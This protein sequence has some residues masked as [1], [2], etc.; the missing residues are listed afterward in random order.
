[1]TASIATVTP[2]PVLTILVP[3]VAALAAV[4]L[5]RRGTVVDFVAIPAGLV[6][7]LLTAIQARG[8]GPSFYRL[9][10]WEAP[11]GVQLRVDGLAAAFL[12]LTAIVAAAVAAYAAAYF[13]QPRAETRIG[14]VFRPLFLLLWGGLNA[15]F[16]AG[17]LFNLYVAL[18]LVTLCAIGLVA[19]GGEARAIAAALRYMLFALA[20]SFAFLTGAVL[21]YGAHGVLDARLTAAAV[22]PQAAT[23]AAGALMTVGLIAKT[24]LFPLHAWLPPA[25]ARAPAPASALLSALVVKASFYTLL[26]LWTEVLGPIGTGGLMTALGLLGAAAVLYGSIAALRQPRL[27]LIIAYS[28]IAQLGLMF[29][30]FPL[31]AGPAAAQPWSEAAWSGAAFQAMAHGLA[32][33]AAFLAAGAILVQ[34]GSDDLAALRGVARRMP[35]SAFAFGLAT[36]SLVGLPPSGGFLAKYLLVSAAAEA[37]AW[38]WAAVPLA[39]GLLS[40]AYL[41]RPLGQMIL[42]PEAGPQP[43]RSPA[44]FRLQAAALVLALCAILL[45]VA[46]L[47]VYRTLHAGGGG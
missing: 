21:L 6:L 42:E 41:L 12:G 9:G 36:V 33:A 4:V 20:G 2:W 23:W 28:T 22:Q 30:A 16:L 39:A 5:G 24:A 1:M 26:R 35:I 15:V 34:V 14:Y 27:K 19:L 43:T 25:H 46:P 47:E 13:R 11:L 37:G 45:G 44:P 17:D 18:E 31:A 10:G 40:A 3:L 7:A 32:K 8:Q 29:L 38:G